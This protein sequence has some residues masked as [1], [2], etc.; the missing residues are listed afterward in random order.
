MDDFEVPIH[1]TA[2]RLM[3]IP[4]NRE[5]HGDSPQ[6]RKDSTPPSQPGVGPV[7]QERRGEPP[8]LF[9]WQKEGFDGFR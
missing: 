7:D 4:G 3:G 5:V 8:G 1:A 9:L 2:G 6:I